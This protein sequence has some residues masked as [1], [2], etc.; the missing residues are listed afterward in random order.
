MQLLIGLGEQIQLLANGAPSPD[1]VLQR[2]SVFT[3]KKAIY[4]GSYKVGLGERSLVL[5]DLWQSSQFSDRYLVWCNANDRPMFF[6]KPPLH[7]VHITD[8]DAVHVP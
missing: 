5:V 4:S 7:V 2:Q 6:V 3:F 1:R 8:V